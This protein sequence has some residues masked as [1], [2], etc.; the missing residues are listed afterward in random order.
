MSVSILIPALNEEQT[1]LRLLPSLIRA[2]E[3]NPVITEI[4]LVSSPSADHTEAICSSESKRRTYV[5]H[6]VL[7]QWMPKFNALTCGAA[8]ANNDWLLVMDADVQASGQTLAA[9]SSLTD[10]SPGIVQA[11]NV[12][13]CFEAILATRSGNSPALLTWAVLTAMAWHW[14]RSQRPD[15]RWAVSAHCYLC[16][17]SVLPTDWPA[18]LL[19]DISIGLNCCNQGHMIRYAPELTVV[20]RPAQTWG[21]FLQ[22][23]LRNRI[24]LAQMHRVAP[25]KIESLRHA[26]RSCL[27][28]GNCLEE[29]FRQRYASA[30]TSLLAIDELL[31][32]LATGL[33][34]VGAGSRGRWRAAKSTKECASSLPSG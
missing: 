22:Q 10:C 19:D 27:F 33:D 32:W 13:D 28:D 12:P 7:M 23:K 17:R 2:V 25:G 4:V 3:L 11:R 16:H 21:D 24:G 15:L 34:V 26:F 30:V 6:L 5:K 14:I 31:W 8:A 20:F 9:L 29:G 18:P 1:L